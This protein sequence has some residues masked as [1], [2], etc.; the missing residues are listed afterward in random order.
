MAMLN[1][2]PAGGITRRLRD[3]ELLKRKKAEAEEKATHQWVHWQ[4]GRGKRQ[5]QEPKTTSRRGR[6]KKEASPELAP[7]I[8]EPLTEEKQQVTTEDPSESAS[9][10]KNAPSADLQQEHNSAPA[11]MEELIALLAPR[12]EHSPLPPPQ[13]VSVPT[14]P[15][16]EEYIPPPPPSPPPPPPPSIDV[17]GHWSVPS[18]D[19]F[20]QSASHDASL[21]STPHKDPPHSQE[22]SS[23]KETSFIE[24]PAMHSGTMDDA[25]IVEDVGSDEEED[26]I[27]PSKQSVLQ[28]YPEVIEDQPA[29]A[30]AAQC[31]DEAFNTSRMPAIPAEEYLP[32]SYS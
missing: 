19:D 10:D 4:Q 21:P 16:Q 18:K 28:I 3:R 32:G 9:Q 2:I 25:I 20:P 31:P 22:E 14:A 23:H 27:I 17:Y 29:A 13:E 24:P 1:D 7:A 5:K 8:E 15:T 26:Q 12:E 30:A 11:A 6:R